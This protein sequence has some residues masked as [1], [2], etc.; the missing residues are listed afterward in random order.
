MTKQITH[1]SAHKPFMKDWW[2]INMII[3]PTPGSALE[4]WCKDRVTR[5]ADARVIIDIDAYE[6]ATEA[7]FHESNWKEDANGWMTHINDYSNDGSIKVKKVNFD[8]YCV[9]ELEA[10]PGTYR[11]SEY[12]QDN[13]VVT[14][15]IT[16]IK[17][18]LEQE[19]EED[20]DWFFCQLSKLLMTLSMFW[21]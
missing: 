10:F 8:N 18:L 2:F 6:K 7:F 13:L 21:D 4:S 16:M 19:E 15:A 9:S 20:T 17:Q 3:K 12:F 5:Y 1:F 14:G 11:F